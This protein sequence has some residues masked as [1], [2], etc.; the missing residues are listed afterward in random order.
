MVSLLRGH[1]WRFSLYLCLLRQVTCYVVPPANL[2]GALYAEWAHYHWVWLS[3]DRA[4]QSSMMQ[5]AQDYLD[6]GIQ[7]GAVDLDM[8]WSTANG[9]FNFDTTKYPNATEMV[10][11][12]HSKGIRV[13]LWVTSAVDTDSPNFQEAYDNGYFIRDIFGKQSLFKW[14]HGTGGLLDYTNEEAVQWWHG[15]IDQVLSLGIDG[16]KCD[17]TDVFIVKLVVPIGKGGVVTRKEYSDAYYGDFFD[18]TRAKLGDDRLIMSR[19]VDGYDF[20]FLDW[21]PQ[22]VVFSGWV[23][24]EDPTFDGLV[25]ALKRYL[26][27]A[28]AGY[29]NFGSD[30]GGYRTGNGTLGR[31]KE[32]FLR[33]SQLGAFSPLME[34][35]GEVEHRPWMFDNNN[36][37]LDIYK[38]FVDTH[39][40]LVD[41]LLTTGTE[42]FETNTSSITPLAKHSSFIDKLID[43]FNPDTYNYL[44]GPNIL[45]APITSNDST[46]NITF[47]V[48]SSWIYWWDHSKVYQGGSALQ[49][50]AVPL[51]EFPVFFKN[52]TFL[53]LRVTPGMPLLGEA[54]FAGHLCWLLHS[55]SMTSPHASHSSHIRQH[56]GPGITATYWWL[57]PGC[58]AIEI[59]AHPLVNSIVHLTGLESHVVRVHTLT[60]EGGWKPVGEATSLEDV[61][62][63]APAYWHPVGGTSSVFLYPGPSGE[64]GHRMDVCF[65]I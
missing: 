12:F 31:T 55:P 13:I 9:D 2:R 63:V 60:A 58:I 54:G 33:W 49:L 36:Q 22:R 52:G 59:S 35:G 29:P 57:D 11:F 6:H 34:N 5:Y 53:P 47:P 18:Y 21:S 56:Q 28:W 14:W 40:Q 45:V 64:E 17:G 26:Q 41:Y 42:A 46:V 37:T 30:I 25:Q 39:Y 8:G 3:S 4:N 20:I 65:E 38:M 44:L 48:G 19:P 27:S 24:D 61:R 50:T 1:L 62:G 7:V 16:W 23:G 10:E 51:E 32:L 43:D 15:Q